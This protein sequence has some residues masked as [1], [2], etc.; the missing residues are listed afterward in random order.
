MGRAVSLYEQHELTRQREG[1]T[2]LNPSQD[3]LRTELTTGKFTILVSTEESVVA[4]NGRN[5][6]RS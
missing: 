2:Q 6:N 3:P 5:S 1:L 4:G